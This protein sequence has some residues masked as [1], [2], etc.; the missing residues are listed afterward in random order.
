M[1]V[2]KSATMNQIGTLM[3]EAALPMSIPVNIMQPLLIVLL[4]GHA[5]LQGPGAEAPHT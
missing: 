5:I 1:N 3:D 4:H 2:E